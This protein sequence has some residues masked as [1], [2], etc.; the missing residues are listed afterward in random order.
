MPLG[1]EARRA[2]RGAREGWMDKAGLRELLGN[3]IATGD[4]LSAAERVL[5]RAAVGFLGMPGDGWAYVTPVSFAYADGRVVFHGGEGL[6]ASLLDSQGIICLAVSANPELRLSGGDPC[7]DDF[8]YQS[9]LAFGVAR[10]AG[11]A[12]ERERA[13]RTIVAKYH[14]NA[15]E[16]PLDAKV[17]AQTRV[18]VMDVWELTYKARPR[19]DSS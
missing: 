7:R 6:K 4:R 3:G 15:A 8:T 9:V 18:Y 19:D 12:G 1:L 16:A 11:D 10:L 14:P 5:R 2:A 17:F 13:L